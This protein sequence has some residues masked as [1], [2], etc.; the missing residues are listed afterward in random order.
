MRREKR[1]ERREERRR[2]EGRKERGD[3]FEFQVERMIP[4]FNI[5]KKHEN[6]YYQNQKYYHFKK[7]IRTKE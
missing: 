6:I 5:V 4:N 1:E 2:E 7:N 3:T